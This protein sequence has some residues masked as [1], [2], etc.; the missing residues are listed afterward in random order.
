MM[1]VYHVGI[2]GGKDSTA[3]LLWLVNESGIDRTAIR[4]SFCD[5]DNEH[6]WTYAH[7]RM[8]SEKVFP[9]EWLK[10]ELGFYELAR[11]KSRFP[12]VKTRFCT[13]HLKLFPTQDYIK[14]LMG[15]G[16][17][18]IA[19]SGTR[20]DE[21]PARAK[22]PEREWSDFFACDLW[23]PLL[24]WT[25][26]D[27]WAIHQKYGIPRNPLYDWGAARVGCFPCI[28]S[29]KHEIRE[30]ARSFPERISR[31]RQ[32]ELEMPNGSGF[33]SFFARKYVPEKFRSREIETAG[34]ERVR[35]PTIDD[36]VTWSQT[37]Q[38]GREYETGPQMDM[39]FDIPTCWNKY[40]ACE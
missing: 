32:A 25:V 33:S 23:R 2:S 30:I 3:V 39:G 36:V 35:V 21:S 4:V 37:R 10:P 12:S 34:G 28:M 38:G 27:V 14:R 29:R 16:Y 20:A 26:D 15:D 9:V 18:V 8:L 17:G 11:H 24:H 19:I 40:G 1:D 13:Q 6:E 22:L 31:I 5:T 7:V